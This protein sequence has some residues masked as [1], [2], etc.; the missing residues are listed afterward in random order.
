MVSPDR[1]DYRRLQAKTPLIVLF[2]FAEPALTLS[3][4][5][6]YLMI[7]MFAINIRFR[8]PLRII[9]SIL[10]VRKRAA[11]LPSPNSLVR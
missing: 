1:S 7:A 11:I 9:A 5:C 4:D 3:L 8:C 6:L 10:S 2:K